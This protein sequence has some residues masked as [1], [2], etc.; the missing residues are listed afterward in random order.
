MMGNASRKSYI[1]GFM[2]QVYPEG[3]INLQYYD[4]TVIFLNHD[5][6]AACHLKWIMVCFE[7]IL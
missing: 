3:V 7:Q 5:V 4:D 2:T 1:Q 6:E